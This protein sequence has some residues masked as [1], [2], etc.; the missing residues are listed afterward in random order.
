MIVPAVPKGFTMTGHHFHKLPYCQV[1][2]LEPP[3]TDLQ[4]R[5]ALNHV[6]W[7]CHCWK[8]ISW[9]AQF[10]STT[11]KQLIIIS[12]PSTTNWDIKVQ[13]F[14]TVKYVQRWINV[15]PCNTYLQGLS[16]PLCHLCH[17]QGHGELI[18]LVLVVVGITTNCC[19][20]DQTNH[21]YSIIAC[22]VR[23][24]WSLLRSHW[25]ILYLSLC[26]I[27]ATAYNDRYI[28]HILVS[29]PRN[30]SVTT[31]TK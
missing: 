19:M 3:I 31:P 26:A 7:F 5:P 10:P 30:P 14:W 6:M 16:S 21:V 28:W 11:H 17:Q 12:M 29:H 18:T 27:F 20:F 23:H 13:R 15:Y 4:T 2:P 24:S 8:D 22:N 1:W 9:C 25:L